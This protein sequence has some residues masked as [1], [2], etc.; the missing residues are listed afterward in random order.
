MEAAGEVRSHTPSIP[1]LPSARLPR[2]DLRSS[3]R[4]RVSATLDATLLGA[5]RVVVERALIPDAADVDALRRSARTLLEAD[6]LSDPR[7]YFDFLDEPTRPLAEAREGGRT[8]PGGRVVPR[9]LTSEYRPY[10][11]AA[12]D[13]RHHVTNRDSI[14]LEHWIHDG[15]ARGTV[16][17][18]HGF[19]MGRPRFDAV[20]LFASQWFEMGLDVVLLTL[21]HHGARTPRGARFS[22]ELFAVPDVLRLGEAVREA[23]Y[24]VHLVT[25]WLRARSAG[26]VGL[27]GLSLGGYLSAL[28]AGLMDDLDFVI[29]VVAPACMGDLAWRF[30][31]RTAHARS[32]EAGAL[33]KDE[34]RAAFRVHS[35]LAHRSRIPKERLLIV[36]GRGDRVVPNEHSAALWQHWDEPSIHWFS[37]SHIAPFGR[38][39]VVDAV[40]NHLGSLGVL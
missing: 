6:L 27:L 37:G 4:T 23:V 5:A 16:V 38:R 19:G 28:C 34:L 14:R 24:E 22:G 20:A 12:G 15:A 32:G 13:G 33:T 2:Q 1:S 36:A 39:G 18:L 29:P 11:F 25:G 35:P 3:I 40:G 7:R 8:R 9:S 21:P 31:E 10:V 30:F 26:P 17:A